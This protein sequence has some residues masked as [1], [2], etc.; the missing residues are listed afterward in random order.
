MADEGFKRKLTAILSADVEGY[1]RLMG[2]DEEATVRTLTAYREVLTTL[3]KQHNGKVIDSPGDNLLA[4]FV[5][6][7]DAVQC[8]VAVQK[9]INARNTEL[10]ENRRMQFR[11]GI[12]L[13]DV[14]QEEDRIYGDGVN[15]AARLEALADPG[16]ICI[17]K[18][19]FDQIETKLPLGYEFLGEQTVKNISK[20]VGAYRVL[21]EPRVTVA[22]VSEE[23][24]AW[25]VRRKA[26]LAG[27]IVVVVLAIAAVIWN[28]YLR[29]TTPVVAPA[30]VEKMAFPLPEK[31]SIAVLPFD[32]L[33]GDPEQDYLADGFTENIITAL[34]K[35]PEIFV[36][37]RK[38]TFTYKGKPVK[39]RQVSEELGVRYVLE[40]SVQKADDRLRITAQLIDALE[41]HHLWA[42][43]Y[44]RELRD[45]FALQDE[46][47]MKILT[48][49]E[50]KLTRG[51]MAREYE[52][53]N[54]EAWGYLVRAVS[55]WERV[56]K[57]DNAKARELVE[58]ALKLDPDYTSALVMLGR[59]HTMAA[60][61]GW[62]ESPAE[63]VKQALELAQKAVALRETE[64][65]GH[66]LLAMVYNHQRQHDMAI[67]EGERA[68]ALGPNDGEAHALLAYYLLYAGRFEDAI[69]HIEKAM[70]LHPHY[71]AYFLMVLA[72]CYFMAGRYDES[73]AAN[74]QLL[75]R[76][77]RGEFRIYIGHLGL[78][79][80]YMSLGREEEARFHAA[81][82][83]RANPSYSLEALQSRNP[84]KDPADMERWLDPLR[85]AG[86]PEKQ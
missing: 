72:D 80:N 61:F 13:G 79:V 68:I 20:P 38:S 44:D 46:I 52:T 37:A 71:P 27:G 74:K 32:N 4:E 18:T 12:N 73:I 41:G 16:G 48:A 57:E 1:S 22:A 55:L 86:I 50:V 11:I 43:R 5:S 14:I 49:L 42:E 6:V 59:T 40:G 69:V 8:A 47:T 21:M 24:K 33:S 26:L 17:S 10:P 2:D 58:Q 70:R 84:Y 53:E 3:I 83:L 82:A 34:S 51:E 39:I 45:L 15:I 77:R 23:K 36:I 66:K 62:S 85:K 7:V 30:A 25:P 81:E 19:A 54:L 75:E 31:P 9:E 64:S 78:A 76:A 63:S 29:P 28:F 65:S 35:I 60:R 56:T 67:A